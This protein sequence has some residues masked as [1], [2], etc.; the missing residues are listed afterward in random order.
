MAEAA[1]GVKDAGAVMWAGMG[2]GAELTSITA[3]G[4]KTIKIIKPYAD[5][6]VILDLFNNP[7]G[8]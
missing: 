2:D 1:K 6:K 8:Y 4:A 7:V 5:N 3:T